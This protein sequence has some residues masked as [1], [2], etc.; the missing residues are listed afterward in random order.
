MP[1]SNQSAPDVVPPA[2]IMGDERLR[3]AVSHHREG[4]LQAAEQGYRAI[5]ET[6]PEH[7]EATHC[8]GML[9]LQTGHLH[10]ALALLRKATEINPGC[11]QYWIVLINALTK[12]G[13]I[14][15]AWETLEEAEGRGGLC[16][17]SA[18]RLHLALAK[19]SAARMVMAGENPDA[20]PLSDEAKN[21]IMQT[22]RNGD[23]PG[24]ELQALEMIRRYPRN[25]FGWKA[26]G[27][28][29]KQVRKVEEA[30]GPLEE[31]AALMPDDPETFFNLGLVQKET[32]RTR[33]A[34]ASFRR[35]VQ[36]YP[37]YAEAL[38]NL[39]RLLMASARLE[40]AERV[41][42]QAV[43]LKPDYAQGHN[44]YGNVLYTL[45]RLSEAE[46]S[47]ETALS[48]KPDYA[49]AYKNL[50]V[51][52]SDQGRLD[53]AVASYRAALSL[54]PDY[55]ECHYNLRTLKTYTRDDPHILALREILRTSRVPSER[56]FASFALGKAMEDIMEWDQAFSFY[57]EANTLRKQQL[58]YSIEQDKYLF[59][60][61]K[62][63]FNNSLEVGQV[64][65]DK[66]RPLLVVG[67]PRSGTS[68]VE[69]IL[70]SHSWVYGAGELKNLN[71]LM[72]QNFLDAERDLGTGCQKIA[73]AYFEAL[74]DLAEGKGCIVDKMP[75]NFRWLGFLLAVNPEVRVVHTMRSAMAICWS[76][77]KLNFPA[78]GLGF[79]YDLSDLAIYYRLYEDL[80]AFWHEKFPGRIYD[81]DYEK[82]T[83]HQEEET[84][85]L[86]DYCGLPWEE[87][88]L[89]FHETKRV[90]KTAS[91]AQIRNKMYQGSSEAWKKFEKHLAPLKTELGIQ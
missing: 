50:G 59:E 3:E 41:C 84:R 7:A 53:E 69:Q 38:S 13:D 58:G 2:E 62:L 89:S 80:M 71:V 40:E 68:L 28:A 42:M 83:E 45:G 43:L 77:F 75:L 52:L 19:M 8:L 33:E 30:L 15:G 74:A 81:L 24:V 32:G 76:N 78:E 55:S 87:E 22:F 51:V 31:A 35:A 10:D 16:R 39:G 48:L 23:F 79:A 57:Q 12:S 34:E 61:I 37:D 26:L 6:C 18:L 85:K 66:V 20:S 56:I 65:C 91:A 72:E 44:A 49:E 46:T 1:V 4:R 27:A 29:L 17:V 88:C 64:A 5:L 14:D 60:R 70:S 54:K 47:F 63:S 21:R 90:V 9:A 86:L 11:E 73:H 36:L 25:G 82:L 67:M